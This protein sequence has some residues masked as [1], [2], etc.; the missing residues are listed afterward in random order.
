MSKVTARGVRGGLDGLTPTAG[1]LRAQASQGLESRNRVISSQEEL[2][3][4]TGGS[5][6]AWRSYSVND[7]DVLVNRWF[8]SSRA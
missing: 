6:P 2:F 3:Q 7:A 4:A 1:G 8:F 5:Y